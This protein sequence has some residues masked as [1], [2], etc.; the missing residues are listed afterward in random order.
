MIDKVNELLRLRQTGIVFDPSK[1]IE[2]QDAGIPVIQWNSQQHNSDGDT[3]V[4]PLRRIAKH[5]KN[6]TNDNDDSNRKRVTDIH[7]PL[8]KPRFGFKTDSTMGA[9]LVHYIEF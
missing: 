9:C 7:C 6:H 4:Y 3:N 2:V 5:I 1:H 8:I